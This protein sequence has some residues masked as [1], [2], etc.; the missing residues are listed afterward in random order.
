MGSDGRVDEVRR[1]VLSG[2]SEYEEGGDWK[3]EET[4]VSASRVEEENAK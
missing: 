3:G 4:G 2:M 1:E